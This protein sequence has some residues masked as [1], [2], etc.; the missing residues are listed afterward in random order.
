MTSPQYPG[1][2][3]GYPQ[4]QGFP[5]QQG[6]PQQGFPG[7]PGTP[8][9]GFPDPQAYPGQPGPQGGFPYQGQQPP[10]AWNAG[11]QFGQYPGGP[12]PKKKT[13]LIVGLV[14]AAVLLIGGG[15]TAILLLTGDDDGDGGSGSYG[16]SDQDQVTA[17]ADQL[18]QAFNARDMNTINN[19]A[20]SPIEE[21]FSNVPDGVVLERTGEVVVNGDTATIPLAKAQGSRREEGQFLARKNGG[22]WCL[23][24]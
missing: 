23:D 17:L 9:Q 6:T 15:V 8:Q 24:L 16:G 21:G 18:V 11:P 4:Q 12:A 1:G 22:E 7:Q 14:I 10:G 20:C 19:I 5:G 13:G 2:P 3:Q